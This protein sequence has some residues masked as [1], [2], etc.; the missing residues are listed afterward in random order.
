MV[1]RLNVKSFAVIIA[2]TF[3][4]VISIYPLPAQ[5]EIFS[6]SAAVVLVTLIFWSSG[7]VPGREHTLLNF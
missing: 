2:L 6:R 4:F 5:S 1:S 3:A 7:F